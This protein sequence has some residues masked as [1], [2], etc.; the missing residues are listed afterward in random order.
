MTTENFLYIIWKFLKIYLL[1]NDAQ[2][3]KINIFTHFYTFFNC[4]FKF[5]LFYKL[6]FM[7]SGNAN[8]KNVLNYVLALIFFKIINKLEITN[9]FRYFA[10]N[11]V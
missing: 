4:L 7:K 9:D 10:N 6:V 1:A 5:W 3:V 2:D 8:N 11:N